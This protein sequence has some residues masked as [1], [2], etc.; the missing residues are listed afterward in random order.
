MS[1]ERIAI[2][3][4]GE[5]AVRLINAV[6]E[7]NVEH[8]TRLRSIALHTEPDAHAMFVRE[9]DEHYSLG[10]AWF[11]DADGNRRLSYLDYARLEEAL[12]ATNAEAAWVG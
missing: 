8:G 12:V 3:N 9:A 2:V 6:G 4:R 11:D 10:S 7:Y 1:F 5:P